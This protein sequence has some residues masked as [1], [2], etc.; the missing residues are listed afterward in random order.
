[1]PTHR[2]SPNG[3][4]PARDQED[5]DET[6]LVEYLLPTDGLIPPTSSAAHD[7][8]VYVLEGRLAARVGRET[9]MAGVGTII[10]I[11]RGYRSVLW[12]GGATGDGPAARVAVLHVWPAE[13][14]RAGTD[15]KAS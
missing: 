12:D 15:L 7:R 4:D 1:M 14:Q 8:Y 6:Y 3:P 13:D 11:P 2:D 5:P 9:L 10:A